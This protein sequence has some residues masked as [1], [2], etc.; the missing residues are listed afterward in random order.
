MNKHSLYFQSIRRKGTIYSGIINIASS[1][2]YDR[3]TVAV[4]YASKSGCEA[5]IKGLKSHMPNWEE[6]EKRWIISFDQGLTDPD[7]LVL[8]LGLP[9]SFVRIPNAELVLKYK[10]MAPIRF[11]PKLYLFEC[12]PKNPNSAIFSGS[13][14]LTTSGL[15]LNCGQASSVILSSPIRPSDKVHLSNRKG[16]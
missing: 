10:L 5:L 13:G 11:H 7:A 2:K 1:A 8:L 15:Y 12:F 3:L 9:N 4:A 6:V 16:I 14:N